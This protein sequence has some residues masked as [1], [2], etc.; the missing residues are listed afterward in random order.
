MPPENRSALLLLGLFLNEANW[1]RKLLVRAA[2]G[3]SD[4]P[5]GQASFALTM[6]LATTLAGKIHEGW[7]R[8]S[9]GRMRGVLD[10]L[11]LPGELSALKATIAARLAG[12]EPEGEQGQPKT[13]G[14]KKA[15]L[16]L[17]IRNNIAFHYPDRKFDFAKLDAHIDDTDTIVYMTPQGYGGDV[18]CHLS[19]LVGIEPILALN[20]DADYRVALQEVWEEVTEVAGMYCT[21]VAEVLASLVMTTVPNVSSETLTIPDAPDAAD[22]SMRFFV[23][24]PDDLEEMRAEVIAAKE[25]T[26]KG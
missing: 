5:E 18:L 2:L 6:L 23:H 20:S 22:D 3:I 10:E 13:E 1:L 4:G 15:R 25:D 16:F 24:P 7:D 19:T 26:K 17:R 8:I 21:F 12:Q 9:N 14:E 11:T